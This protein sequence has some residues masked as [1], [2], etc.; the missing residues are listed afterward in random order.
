M[1]R[2]SL[3]RNTLILSVLL[4]IPVLL[5]SIVNFAIL[6]QRSIR[7]MESDLRIDSQ[8]KLELMRTQLL[9]MYK[10]ASQ[11]RLDTSF[12]T[13]ALEGPD[14]LDTFFAVT[15]TLRENTVW[16]SFFSSVSYYNREMGQVYTSSTVKTTDEFFGK[17]PSALAAAPG[18]A[19]Q[20]TSLEL[21]AADLERLQQT[22]NHVRSMRV[23]NLDGG[24]GVLIAMPLELS[25]NTPP[26]SY[27]LFT[28]SDKTLANMWGAKEGTSCLLLFN[29]VPI[30]SSDA[31]V[32]TSLDAGKGLPGGLLPADRFSYTYEQDGIAVRWQVKKS[33]IMANQLPTILLEMAVTFGVMAVG[34]ALMLY[35]SR[36]NYEPIQKLLQRLPLP[37]NAGPDRVLDEFHYINFVF[38]DLAYSKRFLE[39][40]AEE[41]RRE[42]YLYHILDNQVTPQNALFGQCLA[43]GIRVDRRWFACIVLDD[44]EENY[45]LFEQL[46]AR[47]EVASDGT[48]VYSIYIQGNK[49]LFLLASDQPKPR[50][51]ELLARIRSEGSHVVGVSSVVE[52]VQQVRAA[53]TSIVYGPQEP[54][55]A[56]EPPP[57]NYPALELQALQE[58]VENEN[59]E[60]IA[61]SLRMIKNGLETY[62]ETVRGAVLMAVCT[63]L[64]Q[65]DAKRANTLIGEAP[66]ADAASA[67][68]AMDT[69][70]DACTRRTPPFPAQEGKRLSRN[71]HNILKYVEEHYTSP[72]FS[73]K[74]M[75]A[76]FGTS[77]S[78]LSHQFKKATGQTLSRIIDEMRI[79]KAE[80][81]LASGEQVNTVAQKLGYSTTPVFTETFKRLRGVTPSAYRNSFQFHDTQPQ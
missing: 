60:K 63:T 28:I 24:E 35:Y 26:A 53:Y 79:Q 57:Q 77:P 78:N 15:K 34:L 9:P 56:P 68:R 39:D 43:A 66:H 52:G 69:W 7:T 44:T 30:Y 6:Y 33:L 62:S 4:L 10:L 8:R 59:P 47:G 42:T 31:A 74:Y 75:A 37:A 38:D 40:S 67:R 17:Q 46:T 5:V 80:K 72:N 32:R 20:N 11:Q 12:S 19:Y 49:Y 55:D 22:G 70:L 14:T 41:M 64:C 71:L 54:A 58:A 25:E 18:G 50:V 81:L 65:G 21:R 2:T 16:A 23:R 73:I 3:R 13:A 48:D 51:E 36:K 45:A 61:F 76:E 29:D 27:L 1:W